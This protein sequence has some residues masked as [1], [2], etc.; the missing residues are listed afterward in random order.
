MMMMMMMM[1][2]VLSC[3]THALALTIKPEQPS[4]KAIGKT[5]N[6]T[7]SNWPL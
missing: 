3:Q 5:K 1:M 4:E 2:M 7:Y 6:T